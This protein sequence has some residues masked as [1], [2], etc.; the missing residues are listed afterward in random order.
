MATVVFY[1]SWQMECCG[2]P[3]SV[4]DTVSW[5]A[6]TWDD[7]LSFGAGVA[8]DIQW[9]EEHHNGPDDEVWPLAG[10]VTSIRAIWQRYELSTT[11]RMM[12]APVAG[13]VAVENRTTAEGWEGDS[14]QPDGVHRTFIGYVVTLE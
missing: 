11:Q 5:S 1:E 12:M 2:V 14:H 10:A 7:S 6:T 13:D 8:A 4:G 3:F 9:R